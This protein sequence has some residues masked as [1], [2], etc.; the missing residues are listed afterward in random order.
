MIAILVPLL[1]FLA[2]AGFVAYVGT[3]LG[4]LLGVRRRLYL[5]L[6]T[7]AIILAALTTSQLTASWDSVLIDRLYLVSGVL[8]GL[9][10]YVFIWL[11]VFELL[12]PLLRI[13]ARAAGVAVLLLATS[14]TGYGV[15]NANRFETRIIDVTVPNLARPVDVAVLTDVH[16]GGH[17]GKAYLER[18][19]AA[20]NALDPDMIVMAGDLADSNA[21]L[22]DENFTPLSQLR[23]P[24]YFATGNHDTY[25]DENRLLAIAE[26]QGV[27]V[28]HNQIVSVDGLQIA[29]LDYMNGDDRTFDL[30]PSRGKATIE[31][32]LPKLGLDPS[33]PSILIHHSPVG[34]QYA[35]QA[36]VDLFIAGHTHGGGQI[37]PATLLAEWLIY[38]YSNGLYRIGKMQLFVSPGIGTFMLPLRVGTRNELTLLRLRPA[39]RNDRPS[40]GRGAER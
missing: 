40:R 4:S 25:I 1:S 18:V 16:M 5:Y 28:L 19:V 34:I 3:R 32:T 6:I 2:A 14:T 27:H 8:L 36:G 21:I 13:P 22:R 15:W 23:A 10:F 20:I 35:E 39:R 37:F 17:R 9:L 33:R 12:R 38:P 29:S 30:H 26:R 31:M 7:G 24:V 11:L